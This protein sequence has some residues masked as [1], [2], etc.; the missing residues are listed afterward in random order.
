MDAFGPVLAFDCSFKTCSVAI[1]T[2]SEVLAEEDSAEGDDI[3]ALLPVFIERA[4]K[5]SDLFPRDL[6]GVILTHGPGSFTSVRVGISVA[7]G[8]RL[9]LKIPVLGFSSLEN[10]L[11]SALAL[12]AMPRSLEEIIVVLPSHQKLVYYQSFSPS[13]EPL[14]APRIDS[15][16]NLVWN[17]KL[18]EALLVGSDLMAIEEAW[19]SYGNGAPLTTYS[20]NV[21]A[22]FLLRHI[23]R[24]KKTAVD[25]PLEPILVKHLKA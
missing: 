23:D 2:E 21:H 12:I 24:L 9:A 11:L 8:L 1:G 22:R 6:K 13:K 17:K 3:S 19:Y 16:S 15:I 5:K 10:I 20:G 14:E 18:H 25:H 4:I 7:Q